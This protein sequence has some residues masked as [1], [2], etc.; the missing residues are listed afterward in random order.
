MGVEGIALATAFAMLFRFIAHIIYLKK[1]IMNRPLIKSII[2]YLSQTIIVVLTFTIMAFIKIDVNN[3]LSWIG[4]AFITAG[5]VIVL[6]VLV[7]LLLQK[8]EIKLFYRKFFRR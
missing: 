8:K 4:Y 7:N 3:Y 6:I 2:S 5:V 1:W